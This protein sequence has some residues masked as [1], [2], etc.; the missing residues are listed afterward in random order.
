MHAKPH[1]VPVAVCN[2]AR[3]VTH[4]GVMGGV[5]VHAP[6]LPTMYPP[7][8]RDSNR[9][10]E[11]TSPLLLLGLSLPP[12]SSSPLLLVFEFTE[13][14]VSLQQQ[15]VLPHRKQ[16]QRGK[17]QQ[18]RPQQYGAPGHQAGDLRVSDVSVNG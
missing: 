3:C 12:R 16:D 13:L 7:L 8:A 15:S 17:R 5:C 1:V 14:L 11:L 2:L 4:P 9:D 6:S 10:Q 18:F